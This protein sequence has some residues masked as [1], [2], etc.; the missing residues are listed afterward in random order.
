[1]HELS[2]AIEICRIA[3]ARIGPP[4]C[5]AVTE[6]GVL[7][8]RDANVDPDSLA[9]CL[10]ALLREP[11]FGHGRPVLNLVPGDDLRLDYLEVDDADPDD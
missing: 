10:E 1:M 8:G 2:L 9:F 6:V 4:A 5:A 7:V 11:P 3:E